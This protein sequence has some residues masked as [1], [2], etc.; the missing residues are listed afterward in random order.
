MHHTPN[1]GDMDD[2]TA[3]LGAPDPDPTLDEIH[4][5]MRHAA[6]DMGARK[7][8]ATLDTTLRALRAGATVTV[9]CPEL[10][11]ST[12][13]WRAMGGF[14]DLTAVELA[15]ADRGINPAT[16]RRLHPAVTGS[17]ADDLAARIGYL[18]ARLAAELIT[19]V[20]DEDTYDAL[21]DTLVGDPR[22][23]GFRL[24][25]HEARLALGTEV[26]RRLA[27]LV[28]WTLHSIELGRE[29]S[30]RQKLARAEALLT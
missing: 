17:L 21:A 9:I 8:L 5:L 29:D 26:M 30:A 15:A 20:P 28:E 24:A 16:H 3:A 6:A 23:A 25:V 14:R 12:A 19:V 18:T 1:H 13:A 2:V 4:D 10:G 27:M 11:D 7:H 22:A